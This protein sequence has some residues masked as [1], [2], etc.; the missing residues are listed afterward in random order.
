MAT[1]LVV[2]N[3]V[4]SGV[5]LLVTPAARGAPRQGGVTQRIPLGV[6]D[7]GSAAATVDVEPRGRLHVG[8]EI[9]RLRRVIMHRP[10]LEF[11]RLTPRN[12]DELLF[13]DVLGS[14]AR[15]EHEPSPMRCAERGGRSALPR[16]PP[17]R[18]GGPSLA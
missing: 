17:R 4:G 11:R 10:D 5:F 14:R 9:G 12:K 6:T 2:G 8:S 16:R 18:D 15:Q 3:M 1:A 13:D 7:A